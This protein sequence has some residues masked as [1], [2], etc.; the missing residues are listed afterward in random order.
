MPVLAWVVFS[1]LAVDTATFIAS[2][3]MLGTPTA[4]STF[5]FAS[6][7]GG[8]EEF[9]SLNVFA[10]T[11]V[12]IGTLFVLI[13][14][15]E[16]GWNLSVSEQTAV[17]RSTDRRLVHSFLRIPRFHSSS[18]K[19]VWGVVVRGYQPRMTDTDV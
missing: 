18:K 12:S 4:V 19:P 2:V 17:S 16:R 8:D 15:V 10:T 3:V 9:A 1:L 5:V 6:E 11:L 13:A 7:L 14:L